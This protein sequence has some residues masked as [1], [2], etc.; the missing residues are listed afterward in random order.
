MPDEEIPQLSPEE[1]AERDKLQL[2]LIDV[3]PDWKEHWQGMPDFAQKDLTPKQ[4]ILVHF[5]SDEDR[6]AF[7]RLLGQTITDATK[8][9][10][11][12]KAEIGRYADKRFKTDETVLPRHPIYVVSKGRY[13]KRLTSDSLDAMGIP[14]FVVVEESQRELYAARVKPMAQVIVL[15]PRYQEDYDT[16]DDLGATKSKG[17]GAARNFAW[18]HSI[19]AGAAWHW[20]MDDNIN[21]FYRLHNNLKT[22][23]TTGAVFRAMEDFVDR[24]ENV[25]M[26]GPNY[27]MFASRKEPNI[28]PYTI[29]TRIYSCNLIRNDLPHR[30]RGRYNE[31]TD[32]SLRMLLDGIATVQF[33]AFLQLKLTTQTLGGGGYG[34]VL[35]ERG[36]APEVGNARQDAPQP[37]RDRLQ[38]RPLAP[39]G[40]LYALQRAKAQ[41][42]AGARYLGDGQ[43]RNGTRGRRSRAGGGIAWI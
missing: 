15:D 42:E 26:A 7:S 23:A 40:R 29:N 28:K 12:P 4:S 21:G 33:N 43:L 2:N 18:D 3:E 5:K 31:D 13:E 11:Y 16:F 39:P 9:V 10:W 24:Y 19:A 37:G 38:V 1:Q 34:G 27:F 41:E 25:G 32:L 30:W 17:P 8:F 20:V 35:L 6:H 14:H 36:D 22:P